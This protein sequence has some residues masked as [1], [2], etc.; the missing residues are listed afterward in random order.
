MKKVVYYIAAAAA[1][2]GLLLNCGEKAAERP[3]AGKTGKEG[4]GTAAGQDVK[5]PAGLS[6]Y[7]IG[8]RVGR[9]AA[10]SMSGLP[11]DAGDE[12]PVPQECKGNP[13][14]ERGKADGR[15]SVY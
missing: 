10:K 7:E 5:N 11:C 3:D 12:I 15:K 8:F 13:E 2:A 14:T 1:L 9:C 6:C 4:V